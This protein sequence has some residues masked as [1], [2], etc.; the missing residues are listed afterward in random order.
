MAV[1]YLIRHAHAEWVP[2][3]QRSLSP[4]GQ[5]DARCVA[6][7]LS[8]YPITCLCSSPF[9]RAMETVSP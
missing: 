2:D 1:F 5:R 4:Q 6:N 9:R 8:G 7:L 3:E